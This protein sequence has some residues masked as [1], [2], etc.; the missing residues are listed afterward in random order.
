V[1]LAAWLAW[2]FAARVTRYELADT[3]RIEA[4][5]A[6]YPIQA[7]ASGR[8]VSSYLAL[9]RSVKAGEV[10]TELDSDAQRLSLAEEKAHLENIGPQL[11]A[12]SAQ[13]RAE[14]QGGSDDRR[15]LAAS[16]EAAQAQ[17][18]EAE[19][20]AAL[21]ADQASRAIRLHADGILSDADT[22]RARADAQSKRA[23]AENLK[24]SVARLNPELDVR[25]HDRQAR[26][27]QIQAE[28]S[29]LQAEAAASSAAVL[30][31]EYEVEQRR[32]CAPVS[33]RLG[34]C[35][36]LRPG[37]Y[38][39]TGDQLGVIVPQGKLQV[40][41]EFAPS[42]AIG[43]I[44]PGQL[45]IVR[46]QGFPWVQYG[47]LR[48]CVARVADDIRD[49]KVRVELAL[50]TAQT[51]S[52]IPLQHGLPGSVEVQVEQISPAAMLLRSAGKALGSH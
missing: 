31:L 32:L 45:A 21:A 1:L 19:T 6:A 44:H 14:G 23:A 46:L 36:T 13:L 2:A 20:Q 7:N 26:E 28:I 50:D 35:V 12:L 37:S 18:R 30:R 51:H 8:V 40:I 25:E 52:H 16:I 29:K 4:D 49:G 10:L 9:G 15:V 41:A 48:A 39:K 22:Q 43:K 5:G 11:A 42:A 47:T 17:Y 24:A 38:L 34:E 27:T 33:G 3:A